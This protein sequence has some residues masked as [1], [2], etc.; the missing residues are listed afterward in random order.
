MKELRYTL[1]SDGSSDSAFL[2]ILDWL[3]IHDL[4]IGYA[5]QGKWAD[6]RKLPN[7]P[8][9]LSEKIP[10]ALDLYPCELLFIHRDAENESR[11]KRLDEIHKAVKL[12]NISNFPVVS[13][14]PIKM[15]E[16][17]LLFDQPAI[18]KAAGNP[19]SK[20]QITLPALNNVEELSDPKSE[21]LTILVNASELKGRR[22]KN[23]K[24]R[25]AVQRLAEII[26]DYSPLNNL[27]AFQV[28]K[29]DLA[30]TLKNQGWL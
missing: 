28:L 8:K 26:D 3:L 12:A 9:S 1:I 20:C 10:T 21:L 13:V 22:L 4:G 14:I 6:L 24:E 19:N 15:M 23:F 11:Q 5:I 18:R 27:S 7:P 25:Q 2:P 16:A 29:T 17:W 30:E